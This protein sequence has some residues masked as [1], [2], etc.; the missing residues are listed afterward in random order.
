MQTAS[1]RQAS[2]N[3]FF[4]QH[5]Y[6][7]N[8]IHVERVVRTV[9]PTLPRTDEEIEEIYSRNVDTV[10]RVCFSFMKNRSDTED[11]VQET[12]LKLIGCSICFESPQHE[13]AWLIVTASNL[14]KNALRH[15][16]RK[17]KDIDSCS[18][19]SQDMDFESGHILKTIME[20]PTEYK[21]VV[22]MYYYEG[23]STPEIAKLLKTPQSTIRSKLYRAR[24]LL[25]KTLGGELYEQK[26]D[27]QSI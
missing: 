5:F 19:L 13:Q 9:K 27:T 12:F 8:C 15:W 6:A 11:I 4:M 14:C 1:K 3:Y 17:S 24:M 18:G 16:W 20:L 21:T 25:K 26:H 7:F 22:Y 23:Y 2:K 10:Y